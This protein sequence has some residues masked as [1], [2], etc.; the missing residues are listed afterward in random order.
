MYEIIPYP[1]IPMTSCFSL[2]K[3]LF[4]VVH[5]WYHQAIV[6]LVCLHKTQEKA[7]EYEHSNSH[8]LIHYCSLWM[9]NEF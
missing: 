1:L 5:F 4:N 3:R 9:S 2:L 6:L 7:G 8:T